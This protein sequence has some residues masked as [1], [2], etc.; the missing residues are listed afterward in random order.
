MT[1]ESP[2]TE[3]HISVVDHPNDEVPDLGNDINSGEYSQHKE[4]YEVPVME[5]PEPS[6]GDTIP[7]LDALPSKKKKGT[8]G[9][10]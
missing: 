9:R 8:K 10:C 6:C 4:V 5:V 2:A 1:L 7:M 3:D